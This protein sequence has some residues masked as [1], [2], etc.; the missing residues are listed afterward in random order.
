VST[1]TRKISDATDTFAP[2]DTH[3]ASVHT[4]GAEKSREIVG[5]WTF[6]DGTVVGE[7]TDSVTTSGDGRTVF[8]IMRPAELPRGTYTLHVLVNGREVRT[9]D[10]TV[11]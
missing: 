2:T 3:Y 5:R 8:L 10:A 4:S 11:K 7:R 1:P 9:K 6:Q